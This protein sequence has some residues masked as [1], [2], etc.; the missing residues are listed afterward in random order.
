MHLDGDERLDFGAHLAGHLAEDHL[1]VHVQVGDLGHRVLLHS[2]VVALLKPIKGL[3]HLGRPPRL[4][5]G[6]GELRAVLLAPRLARHLRV[7]VDRHLELVLKL[8][9]AVHHDFLEPVLDGPAA[10]EL[11]CKVHLLLVRGEHALAH[12]G[13]QLG[14]GIPLPHDAAD[15]VR[16]LGEVLLHGGRELALGERVDEVDLRDE[17]EAR[18]LATLRLEVVGERAVAQLE[19]GEGDLECLVT[20]I[21]EGRIERVGR[22]TRVRHLLLERGVDTVEALGILG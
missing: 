7:L 18:E 2:L 9:V 4:A 5:R 13:L 8:H 22:V 11:L 14:L 3:V 12:A 20:S 1:H 19:R 6:D 15:A 10:V 17:V 21:L 16:E